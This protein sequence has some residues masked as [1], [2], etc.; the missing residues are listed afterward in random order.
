MGMGWSL[1]RFLINSPPSFSFRSMARLC[2]QSLAYRT[3]RTHAHTHTHTHTVAQTRT[4]T[5]MQEVCLHTKSILHSS[6]K[7]K[8][9][10][11]IQSC[12]GTRTHMH[13]QKHTHTYRKERGRE[14]GRE[15][16]FYVFPLRQRRQSV[17]MIESLCVRERGNEK[18]RRGRERVHCL[19]S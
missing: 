17:R 9:I 13:A 2:T 14:G 6:K 8:A 19:A 12:V 15:R 10:L 1:L 5:H 11:I 16:L 3:A 7:M 4:H 18:Q